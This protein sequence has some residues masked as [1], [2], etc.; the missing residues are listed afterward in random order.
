M[1][2]GELRRWDDD[3]GTIVTTSRASELFLVVGFAEK[4]I[5]SCPDV[6]IF[7]DTQHEIWAWSIVCNWS[8]LVQ[9][10]G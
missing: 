7:H 9:A 2:I 3:S 5:E 6:V 4:V 8:E 10:P 1:E